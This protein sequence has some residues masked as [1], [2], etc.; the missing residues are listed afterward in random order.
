MSFRGNFFLELGANLESRVAHTHPKNTQVPPPGPYPITQ[1]KV[2]SVTYKYNYSK[3]AVTSSVFEASFKVFFD[4]KNR[5]KVH[6]QDPSSGLK[7]TAA[8]I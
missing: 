6:L 7:K 2:R 1:S 5:T 8:E 4:S 3:N